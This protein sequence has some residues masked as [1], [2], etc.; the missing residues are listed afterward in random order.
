[1]NYVLTQN[2][3]KD[4]SNLV[5]NTSVHDVKIRVGK[6]PNIKEFKAHSFILSSK[7]NYF[8]KAF[9]EQWARK[10][11][12]FFISNQPNISP[13]VFEALINLIYSETISIGS[14]ESL[15][16][17]LI[18][19]DELELL[20]IYQQLEKHLLENESAW[21][22]PKD[23]ITLCQ[24]ELL[25]D[26]Y[27][28]AIKLV[29]R[30]PKLIVDS[31]E[32]INLEE[33]HLIQILK[34]DE[35]MLEEIEIWEYL[36]EWGIENTDSISNDD[37]TEWT[38][39]DFS[40]LE[41]TLHNCIPYIRFSQ[42][43][44]EVFNELEFKSI[45]PKD[46]VDD[47]LKY[48]SDPNSK[49][50]LKNL[51]L[52]ASAYLLDSKII[53]AKDVAVIASWIDKKKGI[54]YRTK[55]IPF[56]FELIY[57]ASLERFN[58]NKFHECCD[59]KGPTVVVI[60]VRKS[61]EIIGGYN[62]LDWR[63]DH[64]YQASDSFLFSL[65][66]LTNGVIPIL[67][68]ISSKNEAIIWCKNKGPCFGFQ[69]LWIRSD[70]RFGKSKQKSYEKKII[71]N[72][73]FNIAEYEVFQVIDKRFSFFKLIKEIYDFI[74]TVEKRF[75]ENV[76]KKFRGIVRKI[77]HS[78]LALLVF[79]IFKFFKFGVTLFNYVLLIILLGGVLVKDIIVK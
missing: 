21:K 39:M 29:C 59:N 72:E 67:S 14:N 3:S 47:V 5:K 43:P 22:F 53:N 61:G 60:K 44:P 48:F 56:K 73:S 36:I 23:F 42:M 78:D 18:V 74:E 16:D 65:F 6:K 46:L 2:S 64:E 58:I 11:E 7:S 24:H 63:S 45:L 26:L 54:P 57:R 71:D 55:D 77:I 38:P 15:V 68:R 20:E 30:N 34:C 62:P 41:R 10:E 28:F 32:F 31:K 27:Q 37:F 75:R 35:L 13:T 50:L 69:D 9:S 76:E 52:R 19:S 33:Q 51:P 70:S 66:S 8:K 17:V 79:I 40:E 1:M 49:P 12:G 4:P 25:T